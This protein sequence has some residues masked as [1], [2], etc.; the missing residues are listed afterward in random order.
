MGGLARGGPS[1]QQSQPGNKEGWGY[2]ERGRGLCQCPSRNSYI[3][4]YLILFATII[5]I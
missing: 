1:A 5:Q 2:S 3:S 4:A